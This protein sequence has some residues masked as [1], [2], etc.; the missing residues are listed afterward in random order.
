MPP[1]AVNLPTPSETCM[2]SR[3]VPCVMWTSPGVPSYPS[4]LHFGRIYNTKNTI[5]V[6]ITIFDRDAVKQA[7]ELNVYASMCARKT[8]YT[9]GMCLGRRRVFRF[10]ANCWSRGFHEK[11]TSLKY[12]HT[13]TRTPTGLAAQSN[14]NGSTSLVK[15]LSCQSMLTV[16]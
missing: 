3:P 11:H 16:Y 6:A 9:P 1:C 7:T 8:N 4:V 10:K 5:F 13:H 14:V 15:T 12:I 2:V